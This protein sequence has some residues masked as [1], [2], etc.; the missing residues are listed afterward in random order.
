[1]KTNIFITLFFITSI[2]MIN[3]DN[4]RVGLYYCGSTLMTLG[5][6]AAQIAQAGRSDDRS[7][8]NN[9][10][11]YCVGGPDGTISE[12]AACSNGCKNNGEGDTCA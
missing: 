5:D 10:I 11:F 3:G 9:M 1:M 7:V 8:T 6:Y 4:C 2:T 12:E